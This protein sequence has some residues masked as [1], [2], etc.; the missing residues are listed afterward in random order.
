MKAINKDIITKTEILCDFFWDEVKA[1]IFQE[2]SFAQKES[3]KTSILTELESKCSKEKVPFNYVLRVLNINK[4][5]QDIH[6]Q[7]ANKARS[8]KCLKERV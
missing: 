3:I 2:M 6:T 4:F 8:Q 7:F 1:K 5:Y